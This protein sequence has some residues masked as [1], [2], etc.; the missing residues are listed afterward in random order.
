MFSLQ[1]VPTNPCYIKRGLIQKLQYSMHF[2]KAD[3]T[4]RKG[5]IKVD[6]KKP[7][8]LVVKDDLALL[9]HLTEEII[10]EN[11]TSRYE[12]DKF[13]TYI[14]EILLAINPYKDIGIYGYKDMLKYRNSSKS[15]NPPHIFAM[16][17]HAYHAM[18][19]EK[20]NQR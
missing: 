20:R 4:V 8:E 17:N 16:A 6:R 12:N 9:E 2:N 5:H 11:L 19:H 18:I 15:D 14:G 13:Y 3:T 7:K 10:I 1:G